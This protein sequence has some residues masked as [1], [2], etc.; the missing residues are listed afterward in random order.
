M[1]EALME[2]KAKAFMVEAKD[3]AEGG[4]LDNGATYDTVK[5]HIVQQV[6]KNFEYGHDIACSLRDLTLKDLNSERPVRPTSSA[7]DAEVKKQEQAGL[8]MFF[9]AEVKVFIERKQKLEQNTKKVYATI[10]G[11][12]SKTIQN[13]IEAHA[14]Y[15]T[16][17][18]DDPIELLKAIKLWC[19]ILNVQS[20]RM[21]H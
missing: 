11:Y 5:D 8:D 15:E 12:C 1:E 19:M 7:T 18:R 20:T 9:N 17:I 16:T 3:E 2:E 14:S 21:H 13:R 10:W 6:Q 4:D